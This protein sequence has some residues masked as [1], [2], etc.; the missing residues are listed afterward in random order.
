MLTLSKARRLTNEVRTNNELRREAF[1]MSL[2]VSIILL[3]ALSVFDDSNPPDKGAVLLLE[4]GTTIGLVLAHGFASWVSTR[5]IGR[6]DEH[7][8]PGDLLL[9][10]LAGAAVVGSLA[11]VA[12]VIVPTSVEL[13]AARLTVAGT[14]AALVFHETR[15]THS[16]LRAAA[17]GLLALL[18]G[19]AVA[20]IKSLLVH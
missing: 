8:D 16:P 4:V 17:Y 12:V 7:T 2:Y 14:I 10:Q 13:L 1:S 3:S 18:A 11:A 20:N 6:G 15:R 19:V 5:I 9:V